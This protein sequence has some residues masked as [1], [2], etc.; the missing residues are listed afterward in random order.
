V[1]LL[2]KLSN[3]I[4]GAGIW[5]NTQRPEWNDANNALVGNGVSM[6]TVNYLRRHL[7]FL[8]ELFGPFAD[9]EVTVSREVNRWLVAI[10]AVLRRHK[11]LLRG[12]ITDGQRRLVLDK[13]GRAGSVYRGQIYRHGFSG[14]KGKVA[15]R[16][17]LG[18]IR[19]VQ[20]WVEHTIAANR[21]SDGLYE[22]YNLIR[23]D[24]NSGIRI[25]RLYPMLEG[26]VAV[27]SSGLSR[28]GSRLSFSPRCVIAP[29]FALTNT[30]TCSIQTGGCPGSWRRTS[31]RPGGS[32]DRP[33]CE[34]S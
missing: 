3:F 10:H 29:S 16:T 23:L 20:E 7:A 27:L 31:F 32:P 15:G 13:L 5:L 9:R 1:P 30:A 22:A 28:P 18:F 33:C 8:A 11:H 6:V 19:Q 14:R 25:R 34:S 12:R 24:P 2:A 26:Q 21:R 4:P 17:L